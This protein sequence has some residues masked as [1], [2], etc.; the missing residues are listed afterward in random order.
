MNYQE[1]FLLN[2]ESHLNL[3]EYQTF[4]QTVTTIKKKDKEKKQEK[5]KKQGNE[6]T[7]ECNSL[8]LS[9][10]ARAE[11]SSKRNK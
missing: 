1:E 7:P 10:S 4:H 8:T 9:I 11:V 3:N 6:L 2:Q 5:I